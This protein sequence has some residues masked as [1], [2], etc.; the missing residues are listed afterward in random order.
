MSLN[1][2]LIRSSFEQAKPIGPKVVGKFYE[3]LFGD[4]P[5]SKAL[6]TEVNMPQQQKA[7]LSSLVYIVEHLHDQKALH[8]YLFKMGQR[9]FEYGVSEFHYDWVGASLLKTFAFFF[10]DAWTVELKDEWTRAYG[11]IKAL[12]MEGQSSM[13]VDSSLIRKRASEICNSLILQI[14]E[15]EL[16]EEVVAAIRDRVRETIL[17]CLDEESAKILKQAI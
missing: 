5:Q 2:E 12:M 10:K 13:R 4:Y 16:N 9:H 8:G 1:I 14:L 6:F 3:I 7:L 15:S 11:A 17:A